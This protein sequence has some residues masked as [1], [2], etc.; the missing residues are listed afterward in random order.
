MKI[1][2]QRS[3]NDHRG[4]RC[5]STLFFIN[6]FV[7]FHAAE[8]GF[9]QNPP[10]PPVITEP[11]TDG[12][13]V[14]PA[15]VH[16]ETQPM[17]DPDPGNTHVC[18]DWEIWS[19]SPAEMVWVAGC[20]SGVE[21]VHIHL[22]DGSFVGSYT[23]RTELSYDTA[24]RLQVRHLDNT[25]RWSNYAERSFA[26]GEPTQS[27]PLELNDVNDFP[28]PRVT[29]ENSVDII[30]PALASIRLESGA[31]DLLLEISGVGGIA[32]QVSNPPP[33][34]S[35]QPV[36]VVISAGSNGAAL[37]LSTLIITSDDGIDHTI[38][39]PSVNLPPSQLAYF[40]IS[41][42]GSSYLGE[43]TQTTP[44]F[45]TLTRG[46]A[47]PWIVAQRGY[48]VEIVATGFQLPVNIAFA[49]N[50]G[51]QPEDPLYYVS[52][53]Y[54]AIKVVTHGGTVIDYAS[55]LLNF[56]PTGDF[57]GS[58]EQGV[59]GIVVDPAS[60]DLFANMLYDAVPPSG[61]HYPKVVRF[62]SDD[63]GLTAATQTTILD[64][65][66]EE[67]GQSHFIS[68]LSIGPDGKLYVHM[69]DGFDAATALNLNSFRGKIL[70]LNL[71]GAAPDDNPF[72]D[73]SNGITATD[74][75]FAY[76]VRNPFG[77]A[78]R[79][80]DGF[81]YEVE[82]GPSIDRLLKV[83]RG[84]NNGWN[85]TDASM[86]INAIYN[87]NPAHAPVNIAFIQPQ[88]FAGSGFP[89]DKMDHAF[90]TESGPTWASG[91]QARGKRIVE[92]VLDASGNWLSG[93][94][95]LVEYQGPGKASAS[96]LAAGPDGLYFTDL[97]KDVDYVSPIDRGANVLRVKFTGTADFA[98]NVTIGA[99]PLTVQFTD[100]S[101]VPSPF[102]WHWNFG[103]STTSAEHNPA[104]T[105]TDEGVYDVRLSVTGANGIAIEQKNAYI[106]AGDQPIGLRGDYYNNLDL[107]GTMI[108]RID[109]T[110]DFNW[111]VSAPDPRLDADNF[112]VR[113]TG[114]VEPEFSERYTF[115]ARVDDGVR[116]WVDGVL[117]IDKWI[118]QSVTE[119]S[120]SIDLVGGRHYAIR[121]EY[122]E[123]GGAAVAQLGWQSPRQ[124]KQV[125][126][127]QRLY[128]TQTTEVADRPH[129]PTAFEL[130][131]N[132]PNPFNP[133]TTIEFTIAKESRVHLSIHD[134]LGRQVNRITTNSRHSPGVFR[135]S[136]NGLNQHGERVASGVYFYHLIATPLDGGEPFI[137]TKK[138]ILI[139]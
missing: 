130:K 15:D 79:A 50:P 40:W 98:A 93:P 43:A 28:T 120:G 119:H 19:I 27:F 22:G 127:Q 63:G 58:G 45:S 126:P 73:A 9:A 103:D 61:P 44:D 68:N 99:A 69:G 53:L 92:F 105:Y 1:L 90:V 131:Q 62:H 38:Y 6:V 67:Q 59:S 64:M 87:W 42:N 12:Q 80:S 30:L 39:L 3:S 133:E 48:K 118:D 25:G 81:H 121:M 36:R 76:G 136:W 34:V 125:I 110:I 75:V 128:P 60:G 83:V 95:T 86:L 111:G 41:L 114:Q 137:E 84:S 82:N 2:S 104:H 97:Y 72:Y 21:K 134:L 77:G 132:Y 4:G 11:A 13:I 85:G 55:D 139:R 8:H 52:E 106:I 49:P 101:T 23:G 17:F 56:N 138:M 89:G 96:G 24:Y 71:D 65:P 18:T 117:I 16:M 29:D 54:G 78:W 66:G 112:S 46:V 116:L 91:P 115:F 32:N 94:T 124:A 5:I 74:Y 57:P 107:T 122:Y 123:S 14:H 33:L 31:S 37:P 70:R 113:W 51:T 109:P 47:V 108:T 20:E 10:N 135:R 7:I 102:A 129:T 88:H 35:H 100:L 26:T